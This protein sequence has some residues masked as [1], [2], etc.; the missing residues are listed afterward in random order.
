M[1][2][3]EKQ[4]KRAG[5]FPY[6]TNGAFGN[7]RINNRF[8]VPAGVPAAEAL[9]YPDGTTMEQD[10]D[11]LVARIVGDI[12]VVPLV[13]AFQAHAVGIIQAQVADRTAANPVP[14]L[15]PNL[16]PTTANASEIQYMSDDAARWLYRRNV[17]LQ[18]NQEVVGAGNQV[19]SMGQA[20]DLRCAVRVSKNRPLFIVGVSG[21]L[22]F[23]VGYAL[24]M[25]ATQIE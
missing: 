2:F 10:E 9:A 8:P 19:G 22:A 21:T 17:F 5:W 1:R 12:F 7:E 23:Q 13:A 20:L 14:A 25:Y 6:H 18:A 3:S 15:P 4:K 24:W 16:F 11:Y